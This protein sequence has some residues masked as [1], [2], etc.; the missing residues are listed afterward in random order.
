MCHCVSFLVAAGNSFC[1]YLR[2]FTVQQR[3][4]RDS[5]GRD[6]RQMIF[7]NFNSNVQNLRFCIPD[8]RTDKQTDRQMDGQR[9]LSGVGWVTY[10]FLQVK[11]RYVPQ[12]PYNIWFYM[13]VE[14]GVF[15]F[16]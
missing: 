11:L 15:Y 13:Y 12:F 3:R 7:L 4:N 16:L 6:D 14:N 9:N 1:C 5:K 8:R 10:G 2:T